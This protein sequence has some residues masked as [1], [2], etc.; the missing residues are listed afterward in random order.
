M[1]ASFS[2]EKGNPQNAKLTGW[3]LTQYCSA[4]NDP[5]GSAESCTGKSLSG[6][7]PNQVCAIMDACRNKQVG[8]TAKVTLPDKTTRSF[9]IR[10]H[11][12]TAKTVDIWMG[13]SAK[14]HCNLL[15][16]NC[17]LEIV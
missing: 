9:V 3:R 1:E 7:G 12:G 17:T 14:C 8:K 6:Y 15:V 5:A 13:M 4:C 10:D 2:L 16:N 11:C